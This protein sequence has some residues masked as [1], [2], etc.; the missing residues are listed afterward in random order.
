MKTAYILIGPRGSG[1]THIG[2]LLEKE[3]GIKFFSVE[4]YF[5][6]IAVAE[7]YRSGNDKLF[8]QA[9]REIGETVARYFKDN[10][11]IIFESLGTFNS[12]KEFIKELRRKHEVK[13]IKIKA[14]QELCIS[15]I[16]NRDIAS[17]VSMDEELIERINK[18]A[19]EER[20]PF[21]LVI[22]NEK[23]SDAEIVKAFKDVLL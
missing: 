10:D 16:K 7:D 18:M 2:K 15:R 1:K 12:F 11:R 5:L 13:L 8:V 21:D 4:P 20:Y 3:L 23:T 14:P 6:N 9:W 22:D 19:A 17:H